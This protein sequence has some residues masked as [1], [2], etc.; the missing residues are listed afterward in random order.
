MY[1]NFHFRGRLVHSML[2]YIKCILQKGT[3]DGYNTELPEQLHI[4]LDKDPYQETNRKD[5]IQQMTKI[6]YRIETVDTYIS[7][8]NWATVHYSRK[9]SGVC[10]DEDY[11]EELK[12]IVPDKFDDSD[13]T[14]GQ[15]IL[16]KVISIKSVSVDILEQ[17]YGAKKFIQY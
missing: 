15:V 4:N 3:T 2:H 1:F 12:E 6:L 8:T 16:P 5:Y 13:R 9:D 17:R 7:F 14:Y 10:I 11:F